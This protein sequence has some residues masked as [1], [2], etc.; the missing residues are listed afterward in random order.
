MFFLT[1]RH[2]VLA[3]FHG[4]VLGCALLLLVVSDILLQK[5]HYV[6]YQVF[7]QSHD[8]TIKSLTHEKSRN[9]KLFIKIVV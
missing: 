9:Q 2:R 3:I 8:R 5:I 4:H 1:K 7:Y 6:K